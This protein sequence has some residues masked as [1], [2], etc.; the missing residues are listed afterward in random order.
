MK[1]VK[2][3]KKKRTVENPYITSGYGKSTR[4]KGVHWYKGKWRARLTFKGE[5]Y[6]LG[7]MRKKERTDFL[8]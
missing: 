8:L 3:K 7:E 6:K 1:R 2:K 4:Y 5:I